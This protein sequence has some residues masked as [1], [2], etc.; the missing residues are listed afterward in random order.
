[1]SIEFLRPLHQE[2]LKAYRAQNWDQ[3]EIL[4]ARSRK[5]GTDALATYH[6]VFASRLKTL[7]EADLHAGWDGAYF[8]TE[9]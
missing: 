2:F 4:L 8:M 6:A 5:A 7:R 1:V 9:K 3:A